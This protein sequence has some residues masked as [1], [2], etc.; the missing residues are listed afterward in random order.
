M[1]ADFK[2]KD[3]ELAKKKLGFKQKASKNDLRE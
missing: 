2:I 3:S 1:V